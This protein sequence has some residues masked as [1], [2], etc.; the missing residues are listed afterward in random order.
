[1]EA[2]HDEADKHGHTYRVGG[3]DGGRKYI[4]SM[5]DRRKYQKTEE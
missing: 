2:R 3:H 1:M 5:G 4:K